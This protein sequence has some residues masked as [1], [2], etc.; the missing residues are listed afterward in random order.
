MEFSIA[1]LLENFS[2]QK[3]VAPKV[4]EKKLGISED[5]S[6]IRKLQ[7]ALDALEKVG[8]LEKDK[9]RYR[10]TPEDGLV[11]GKLRCSSKG[12]C[13]AIQDTEGAEDIYIRESRLS[14][15]WNGDRVLVKVTKEGVRRRSPEGEVRLITQRSNP[16]LLAKVKATDSGYRATPLDDRLLFEIELVPDQNVPDLSVAIDKLIHLEMVRYPLGSHLPQGRIAQILG[17][18]AESTADVD[19]VCCKYNLPRKFSDKVLAEVENLPKSFAIENRLDLRSILSVEIGGT[20]AIS[21]TPV[22]QGWNLI[23]HIPDV[24]GYVAIG[25]NIDDAARQRLRSVGLGDTTIPMLP[26]IKFLQQS[27]RLAMSVEIKLEA[28]GTVTSFSIHPSVISV[29][30]VLSYQEAQAVLNNQD[31]GDLSP[32]VKALIHNIVDVSQS[33]QKSRSLAYRLIL[34]QA[35]TQEPDEGN[36]GISVVPEG[37]PIYG[38]V[39]EIMILVNQAIASHL[40]A[41]SLPGIFCSHPAPDPVKIG[42]WLKLLECMGVQVPAIGADQLQP[43]DY[44]NILA[45]I[46]QLPEVTSREIVKYIFLS[47]MRLE[48]YTVEPEPHF[49]LS[50]I[51]QPYIHAV[52]PQHRYGDLLVQRLLH[53]LFSEGRDRR[54]SRIKE[55]VD[56]HSSSCHGQVNWSVLPPD[57]ERQ[58]RAEIELVLPKLNQQENL[59]FKAQ[60]DLE[61]LRKAEYMQARTGENFFGI[62]TGVQSYGFF[63]EIESLLVEGLVHVSSLKDD[64]YEFPQTTT[65]A[66]GRGATVLVGRRSGRQYSLGD[67]VEV[68]VKSVDYYRQQIDLVAVRSSVGNVNNTEFEDELPESLDTFEEFEDVDSEII[69]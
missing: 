19:L 23:V 45:A 46:E 27:E 44:Q 9:G 15:A 12:F 3:L 17:S 21:L 13:F 34:P 55:G 33:L 41:L 10:R 30:A 20:A 31:S 63:V 50:L 56:L 47:L 66:K 42:D 35:K 24:S 26:P 61:S 4:I 60:S 32:E 53:L 7:V 37:I 2:D 18:N 43:Q 49:G 69:S 8:I 57:R 1:Q 39:S 65:R 51:D 64:W 14:T 54:S 22:D 25:S 62:I 58:L 38:L 6:N 52:A 5:E 28:D 67:R 11:E 68:Q 16:T 36:R 48:E 59:F 40:A 29:N